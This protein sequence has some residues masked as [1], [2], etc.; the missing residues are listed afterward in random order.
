MKNLLMFLGLFLSISIAT[1]SCAGEATEATTEEG[2]S[3]DSTSCHKDGKCDSTKCS[4]SCDHEGKCASEGK[5]DGKCS[6]EGKCGGEGKCAEGK[7][8]EGKCGGAESA[9]TTHKCGDAE[10]AEKC[11]H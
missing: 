8:A 4:K 2:A 6:A 3:K 5:C 10:G 11:G 1:V 7:C 9:D